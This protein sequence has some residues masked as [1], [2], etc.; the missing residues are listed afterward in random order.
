MMISHNRVIIYIGFKTQ[1]LIEIILFEVC[2]DIGIKDVEKIGTN[3][4]QHR[5]ISVLLIKIHTIHQSIIIE[6]NAFKLIVSKP[7]QSSFISISI[8]P[9][10]YIVEIIEINRGANS[11]IHQRELPVTLV[12]DL[13]QTWKNSRIKSSP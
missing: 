2:I 5:L 4:E 6:D 9:K 10:F 12:L 11:P 7:C 3:D 8:L 1:I 13:S